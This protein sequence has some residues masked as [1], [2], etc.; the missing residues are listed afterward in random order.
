MTSQVTPEDV[1]ADLKLKL[2][3]L[4]EASNL[5]RVQALDERFEARLD[6][7]MD[8]CRTYRDFL[9]QVGT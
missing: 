7:L 2:K 9:K 1:N 6:T 8:A 5:S 4:N 3:I